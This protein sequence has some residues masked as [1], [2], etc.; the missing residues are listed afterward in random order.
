ME[1][2]NK[3]DESDPKQHTAFIKEKFQ[4]LS[5]HLREDV[6]KVNDPQAKALF[7]VSAEVLDGLKKA[8]ADYESKSE[9][10]WEK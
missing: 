5:D 8:F 10:A 3:T 4:E 2:K 1:T 7:E 9:P 6:R